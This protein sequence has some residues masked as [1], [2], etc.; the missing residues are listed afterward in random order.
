MTIVKAP[1]AIV[2]NR[3]MLPYEV[4][5]NVIR[6]LPG[7]HNEVLWQGTQGGEDTIGGTEGGYLVWPQN[8]VEE[9]VEST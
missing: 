3:P 1:G 6:V 9:V 8:L 5:V 2:H 7:M 4:K